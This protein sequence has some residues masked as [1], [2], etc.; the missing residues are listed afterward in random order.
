M[1]GQDYFKASSLLA[2]LMDDLLANGVRPPTGQAHSRA[3]E[4]GRGNADLPG[5]IQQ[6]RIT[7]SQ[8]ERGEQT[9]EQVMTRLLAAF[10]SAI[11]LDSQLPPKVRY[12][13]ARA[14]Y[15][16]TPSEIL[17][18][19]LMLRAFEA[20]EYAATSTYLAMDRAE[21]LRRFPPKA[22]GVM[23][24]RLDTIDGILKLEAGDVAG[25]VQA[26]ADSAKAVEQSREGRRLWQPPVMLLAQ[27]LLRAGQTAA[28][29]EYLEACAQFE[30][31]G[32]EEYTDIGRNPYAPSQM[33][34]DIRAGREPQFTN[35]G[36]Y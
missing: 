13:Q 25:A 28:V 3:I 7:W 35:L 22:A 24:N 33:L 1:A 29:I 23:I 27:R 20:R 30:Y 31:L 10:G 14:R 5:L 19:Q 8:A 32:S 11:A 9:W 17:L 34:A 36:I 12:E 21:T 26:L 4:E 15:E 2:R 16:A 6:A 18:H